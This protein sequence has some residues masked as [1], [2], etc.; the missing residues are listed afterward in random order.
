MAPYNS[1]RRR[2]IMTKGRNLVMGHRMGAWYQDK[3]NGWLPVVTWLCLQ[4]TTCEWSV[5]QVRWIFIH[6]ALKF[7]FYVQNRCVLLWFD[8]YCINSLRNSSK[9]DLVTVSLAVR[10]ANISTSPWESNYRNFMRKFLLT[11]TL[12]LALQWWAF[13]CPSC[14][15]S[16]YSCDNL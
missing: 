1:Q 14:A 10:W 9:S 4:N 5:L 7:L 3:L 6:W 11:N 8:I 16:T 15:V 2:H 13:H 12:S